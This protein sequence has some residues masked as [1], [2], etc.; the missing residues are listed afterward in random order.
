M[1]EGHALLDTC[2]A[3]V[4]NATGLNFFALFVGQLRVQT[5]QVADGQFLL[6]PLLL[7]D[8]V[9]CF[10]LDQLLVLCFVLP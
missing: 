5:F 7:K 10:R 8:F 9:I 3:S 4:E 6:F 1:L 2:F